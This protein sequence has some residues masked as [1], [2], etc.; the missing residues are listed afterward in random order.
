MD[1]YALISG[2]SELKLS[3]SYCLMD[4]RCPAEGTELLIPFAA[5]LFGHVHDLLRNVIGE[6]KPLEMD[7]QRHQQEKILVVAK[8]VMGLLAASRT[9]MSVPASFMDRLFT[10]LYTYWPF[11]PFGVS[12]PN[13]VHK[14]NN[15]S[16]HDRLSRTVANFMRQNLHVDNG[17]KGNPDQGGFAI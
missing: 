12:S 3:L 15:S 5:T 14:S 17:G 2:Q 11:F 13:S 7:S 6:W 9:Y 8:A 1:R 10:L 16:W 4:G